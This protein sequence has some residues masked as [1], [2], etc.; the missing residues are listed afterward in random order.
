MEQGGREKGFAA[1]ALAPPD[2]DEE[3]DEHEGPEHDEASHQSQALIRRH[4]AADE[5]HQPCR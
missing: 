1:V 3:A 4:D 5:D 2:P